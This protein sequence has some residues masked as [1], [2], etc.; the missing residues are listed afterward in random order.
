M[1]LSKISAIPYFMEAFQDSVC[2]YPQQPMFVD[3]QHPDGFTR[4][5]VD[6]LSGRVYAYL[7]QRGVGREDMVMICLPRGA[8]IVVAMIGVWKAGA[9]CTVA[10]DDLPAERIA[11]IQKDCGSKLVIDGALWPE[12]MQTPPL[13]GFARADD[14]DV[15]FALYTSGSTGTPKGVLQEYGCMRMYAI[16]EDPIESPE[17]A[18]NETL[19]P[20]IHSMTGFCIVVRYMYS[21]DCLHI[22][23]YE[24]VKDPFRLNRYFAEHNISHTFLPTSALRIIGKD[25]SP[26]V[27][28]IAIG[29]EGANGLYLDGVTLE[30]GYSMS[31]VCYPLCKFVIDRPYALCP[32]GKPA[33][34]VIALRLLD[35]DGREVKQGE[36]GEVC[37]ENPF[38]RGYINRPEETKEAFRGG[39]FHSGDLG[40]WDENGNLVVT[41]RVSDMLKIGGNRVEPGEIERVFRKLTGL[42]WCAA[43]GFA[44]GT[45]TL[46]CLYYQGE[47]DLD[48]SQL[49]RE[50]GAYLPGYMIPAKFQRIETVP[51][52]PSGKTDKS[53]LPEPDF[54]ENR[55]AYAPPVTETEQALC[56]A[57]ETAFALAP[58]GLDD[59]F[60]DLGGDSLTAMAVLAEADLPGLGA[61]DIFECRAP[62]IIAQTL[63]QRCAEENEED[64]ALTEARER[65]AVH[66]LPPEMKN[67]LGLPSAGDAHFPALW[68]F[69][70]SVGAERLCDA[71]NRAVA[72]RSALSM[73]V[74]R[75]NTGSPVL[76]YDA[77]F[78]PHFAVHRLTQAA[79]DTL[80]PSLLQTFELYGLPLIHAGVYETER[81]V[82]LFLDVHHMMMDG[83]AMVLLYDDIE[84]A[85]LGEPLGQDTFCTC[86]KNGELDRASERFQKSREVWM[87]LLRDQHLRIGFDHDLSGGPVEATNI[88]GRAIP[89]AA[90]DHVLNRL[91]ISGNLL[92]AGLALLSAAKL[93]G[94][95]R[96]LCACVYHNR[97]DVVRRNAFGSMFVMLPIVLDIRNDCSVKDFFTELKGS[98]T[99]SSANSR[100]ANECLVASGLVDHVM[101]AVYETGEV[102]GGGAFSSMG[103]KHEE[104]GMTVGG[105]MV[106]TVFFF[107]EQPEVIVPILQISRTVFS[108]AKQTAILDALAEVIDRLLAVEHPETTTI[109]E[110]LG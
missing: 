44:V 78:T 25:L 66:P 108:Q 53:A 81:N 42:D 51:L 57:F 10:E 59:D 109:G 19:I 61:L 73:V 88:P 100:V 77:S 33:S 92:Y 89:S 62:R 79:F 87:Q 28:F 98:W 48:A 103:G 27:R 83:S 40:R 68:R 80:R 46:L 64:I 20:P 9:A 86:L 4:A 110:L 41:G 24:T 13:T 17:K 93:E 106:E 38:F 39:L 5:E 70:P 95:G 18:Y 36:T 43:K 52:L 3:A 21:Y 14:H 47:S 37:F 72:N 12:I 101:Y 31:E 32:V 49:R 16:I 29:G 34:D 97:G 2:R 71:L 84:K 67:W 96:C 56:R 90:V 82:Y 104:I 26:T 91:G 11:F 105:D 50:M 23:P 74:E 63:A 54:N 107:M 102:M 45:R 35:P 75:D 60:F 22:L 8:E 6:E 85:Y 94:E 65:A 58:I 15:A 1:D 69:D 99:N 7:K 30:N 76:R 55:P